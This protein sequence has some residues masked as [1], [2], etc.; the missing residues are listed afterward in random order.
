MKCIDIIVIVYIISN[1]ILWGVIYPMEKQRVLCEWEDIGSNYCYDSLAETPTH[2][3]DR[4]GVYYLCPTRGF[5][6][7]DNEG[8]IPLIVILVGVSFAPFLIALYTI[9]QIM[10]FLILTRV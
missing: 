7:I 10:Y 8:K 1:I 3:V 9:I 4:L 5:F 2:P 6:D